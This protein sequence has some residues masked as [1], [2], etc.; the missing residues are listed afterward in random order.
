VD[1][2]I[3]NKEKKL[4]ELHESEEMWWE[5]RSKAPWLQHGDKNTNYFHMKAN[6]RRKKNRIESITDTQ[7]QIQHEDDKIEKVFLDHFQN[8]FKSQVTCNISE[9]VKV[10]EGKISPDMK[11]DL[12]EDFTRIE[13]YQA[14]KDMKALAAPGPDGLPALFYHN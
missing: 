11:K 4:D 2:Q 7:G 6:I 5:Q 14:I 12:S 13:V 1:D 9:A 8:I 10:V 3:R